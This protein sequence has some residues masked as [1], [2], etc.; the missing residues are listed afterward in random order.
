MTKTTIVHE[1]EGV[2][3]TLDADTLAELI[4]RSRHQVTVNG[5]HIVQ[6]I[7]AI[8]PHA[9]DDGPKNRV[10]LHVGH[11]Y[12]DLIAVSGYSCGVA[13][14]DGYALD[15]DPDDSDWYVDVSPVELALVAK[16]F[17]PP[18]DMQIT[19]RIDVLKD[20]RV[21]FTDASGLDLGLGRAY[22]VPS[23]GG[24]DKFP[25]VRNVILGHMNHPRAITG[26]VTYTG[27]NLKRFAATAAAYGLNVV[28]EPTNSNRPFI[29][30][31]GDK[32][33][34]A[35]VPV[36]QENADRPDRAV[37]KI[38]NEWRARLTVLPPFL[39][40]DHD[41]D[42][43]EGVDTETGEIQ[44]PAGDGDAPAGESANDD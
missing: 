4:R 7:A 2:T 41:D 42:P 32:F 12:L 8:I 24:A 38:R 1:G 3:A 9:A 33:V 35:L 22:T 5:E 23:V 43:P 30:T 13:R 40:T 29:V 44:Q 36:R 16:L 15:V 11:D 27:N 28:V 10:R 14:I 34:G 31:V 39:A 21:A 18:K 25:D 6:A 26:C 19:L 17:K 37:E 20:G